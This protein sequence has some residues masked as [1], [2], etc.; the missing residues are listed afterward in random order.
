M[1]ILVALMSLSGLVMP[2]LPMS[3]QMIPT[4]ST[5]AERSF[6]A[7]LMLL[8]L[9]L[10][11]LLLLMLLRLLLLL[12]LLLLPRIDRRRILVEPPEPCVTL[13]RLSLGRFRLLRLSLLSGLS[14]RLRLGRRG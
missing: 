13:L 10:V 11:V 3:K 9:L 2:L 12:C 4:E 8:L 7:L 1:G 14:L 5:G 6:V